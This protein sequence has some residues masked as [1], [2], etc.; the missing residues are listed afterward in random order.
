MYNLT[1]T[2][3]LGVLQEHKWENAMTID[4]ISWGYRRNA[5]LEDYLT[6]H[7]LITELVVTVSTGGK[8][9]FY[10]NF[11]TCKN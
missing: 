6:T 10:N 8:K 3:F 5:R 1:K 9:R 7:E 4:K 2:L 11:A